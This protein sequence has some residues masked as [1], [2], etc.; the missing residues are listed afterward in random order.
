MSQTSQAPQAPT[1]PR[2]SAEDRLLG[3]LYQFVNLHEC[4][5]KDRETFVAQIAQLEETI[6]TLSHEASSLSE[7][8]SAIQQQVQG[9][10]RQAGTQIA[11]AV[12]QETHSLMEQA[13]SWFSESTCPGGERSGILVRAS[14]VA[15]PLAE[16][17]KCWVSIWWSR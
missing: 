14:S 1:P 3:V 17:G 4:W 11:Q 5:S 16:M 10:I 2:L 8:K 15:N 13:M 7:L 9:S 12:K 6:E